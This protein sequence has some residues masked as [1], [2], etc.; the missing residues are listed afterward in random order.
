MDEYAIYL[1]FILYKH[2]KITVLS[3]RAD[4]HDDLDAMKKTQIIY[5]GNLN[6]YKKED[7]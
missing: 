7:I 5:N 2:I 4:T 1:F 3:K 6:P